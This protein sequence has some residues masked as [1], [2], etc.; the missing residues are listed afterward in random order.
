MNATIDLLG[1]QITEELYAGNRT[2]VYRGMRRSD[3]QPVVIKLLRNE[4]PSFNELVQFRNQYTIAKNLDS[5]NIINTYNLEHYNNGYAL[6]MEDFGGISLKQWIDK[7]SGLAL[8]DFLLIAIDL[9]ATLDIL[10]QERIIHKDI[11]PAN[12]LIN[13]ETKQIKLIDFSIASLLPR[14]TQEI[15]NANSLEGTLAY[16]APEQTGRMNRGIDYRS[17]FYSLGVTFYELLTGTLPFQSNDPMELVHYHLAKTPI[18]VHEI[19]P[20]IPLVLSKIITRLMAKNAENRYQSA[21]GIKHDLEN[22]WEQLQ[23]TGNIESFEIGQRDI[24]DRFT[25][26]EKLYGRAQEVHQLLEAFERVADGASELMLVAGFS[27]IG[28]TA[29]VN[30]VHKPIVRQHGYFIK[31]KFDQ[32]NR[33]IPLS[34]FVQALR[35]LMG[36]LLSESDAQLQTWKAKILSAIGDNGQVLIE[37]IPELELII[38]EQPAATELSGTAAQNRFNL[39]FQKFIEVFTTVEHPLV[40]FLDDLQWAD[41]ASLQLIKL[42]MSDNGY[43]L[44]LG[45]YRDNEVSPIHPFILTVEEIKKANAIVNTITLAPLAFED[46]NHLVADTLNC[47]REL[48]QPLTELIDRKT[49]GNP[50]FTTQFLK[51]LHEDGEIAF[52]RDRRY[53]ECDIAQV[54][55]LALT[56]DVVEFMALQLQKLPAATQHLLK[57]AACIGN[58][59]GLATLAIVSEQSPIYV[60]TALWKAL[61]EGLILP[62]SQ[63]YK[64]FQDAEQSNL[65]NSVYPTYRFLHDRVQQAAYS[66]ISDNLKKANHLKIGQLLLQ[67]SSEKE[68]EEKIFDL[69]NSL[70]KGVELL[71]D[72]KERKEIAKLNLRAAQKAKKSVAYSEAESY[73]KAAISL[74]DQQDWEENYNI[75]LI[76]YSE[77]AETQY[78]SGQPENVDITSAIVLRHAHSLTDS[79]PVYCT[80]ISSYQA[81][82][83]LIEGLELGLQV[84]DKLG[85][86]IPKDITEKQVK[87][88]LSQTLQKFHNKSIEELINNPYSGDQNLPHIQSILTLMIG[89]SYKA[90]PQLLPFIACEQVELTIERG[91]LPAS[92]SIYAIYG[93]LLCGAQD[94]ESG[95][96]TGEVALRLMDRF[97]ERQFETRVLNLVFGYINPWKS[98]LKDSLPHLK[99][100]F[101]TGLETGD[102]EYASYCIYHY[103]QFLFASGES[104]GAVDHEI[105]L[106]CQALQI[107]K[108]EAILYLLKILRQ[109]V[110]NLKGESNEYWCLEG[111][112]FAMSKLLPYL[113]SSNNR[114]SIGFAYIYQLKLSYLFNKIS[115]AI[116]FSTLAFDDVGSLLGDICIPKLHFYRSL[117]YLAAQKEQLSILPTDEIFSIVEGDIET[118]KWLTNYAPMNF[119]HQVHLIEAEKFCVL[120]Q[121]LEAIEYYDRAISGAKENGYIQEEALANELAAKFYLNWGKEKIAASYMQDAYYCYAHW[122]AKAKIQ[123]LESRYPQLLAPILKQQ[124]IALSATETVFA[125]ISLATSQATA[126]QTS[127]S[128]STSISAALD[129][130]TILKASQTL[131]EIQLDKLLATLLHTVLENAGADKGVLLMPRENQWYVEAIATVNQPAQ[132][133]S[134]ALSSSSEVPQSLI[135][136]VKRSREPV[137]VVNTLTHPTLAMD[138]YVLAQQ[139]KSLLCTPILNQGKLV[140]ILY[141]EN[142]VTVGAFT[143]DRVQLLN[144][145]CTQAAISLENARLYQQAQNYAQQLE[146][147]QLQIVQSE[148]M[149]SLGNLVAGVAHEINNPIGFLNGS[150]DNAKE[151][152][153]DLLGHLILYQQ[154]YPNPVAPIQDNAEEI[155]LEFLGEDLPKSLDSMQ[156]AI[157]RIKGISTSLRTF[158]RTDT[159]YK[160]S[161][162]LH[163]GIDSTILILKYRLKANEHHPEIQVIQDYG[164]LPP[165]QCFPGQLNQVFMNILANAIDAFEEANYGQSFAEIQAKPNKITITTTVVDRHVQ[166]SIIDNGNGM[167]EE[168]KA[169]IFNHLFTTKEVGKGTGLGLVIARQIVAEKH[170]GSIEVNSKLGAGTEFIITLPIQAT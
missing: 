135:N 30:E 111:E 91:N 65:Q 53:W 127:A 113:Q 163:E 128:S 80:Q 38:G 40:V 64:F 50:F 103:S 13:P 161:A 56:D 4:F 93:M 2:L 144:F 12:I 168:I 24:S 153:Q 145:L 149:A 151:N 170:G 147:S 8:G 137:V 10:Y 88:K 121:K 162:N 89:C 92:A 66:L 115:Q 60:A 62:T 129:L 107:S 26:P 102:L 5:P 63:A 15:Q 77:L 104:L 45:A 134:I 31:G 37:V 69:V 7:E 86:F 58:Q 141:L 116:E 1:Y 32:F 90:N 83:K 100:G 71:D 41:S 150:I 36:Q 3:K 25:I 17:D 122:G 120:D 27:G 119:E 142:H 105:G 114:I 164:D 16:I 61:H 39:L 34:A 48:A 133:Q 132:I 117:S 9:C 54:N 14:E 6:I 78:L 130:A 167:T 59:F 108:Q 139:P 166:I 55:A 123:D 94:F 148:K 76:L 136:T 52:D 22:C 43:L 11:K 138:A 85:V 21:L 146:Q 67:T 98:R 72:L 156:E 106:Y 97:P 35:D 110:L 29:V 75:N 81:Q 87:Q 169:K 23:A 19:N 159:E 33:N 118:L 57:L 165:I 131:S 140:A 42:L 49:K 95:F 126:T 96:R 73:F 84:L 28:K 79:I 160:V 154:H 44:M 157:D 143:S 152:L 68:Q 70:N 47:S 51:A 18:F 124:Q 82:G 46:T 112:V 99:K 155:D 109:T 125:T 20:K 158:S 74:L 101:A